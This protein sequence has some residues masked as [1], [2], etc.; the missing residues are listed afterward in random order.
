MPLKKSFQKREK[1]EKSAPQQV[2]PVDK[3]R[4]AW[5]FLAAA[6]ATNIITY[7][8]YSHLAIS[9]LPYGVFYCTRLTGSG[10]SSTFGVFREYYF[11]H[12]P[13]EGSQEV[14]YVGPVGLVSSCTFQTTGT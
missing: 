7:G 14:A 13:F 10:F 1:D 6:S 2:H 5:T 4:K 8:R 3:G 11:R 9:L 12:A